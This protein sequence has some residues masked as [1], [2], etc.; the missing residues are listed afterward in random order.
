[1]VMG[2][3]APWSSSGIGVLAELLL[4]LLADESVRCL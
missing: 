3:S 4:L 2:I 1:M